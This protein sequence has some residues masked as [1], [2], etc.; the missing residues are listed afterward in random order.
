VSLQHCPSDCHAH[1]LQTWSGVAGGS[2]A[3]PDHEYPSHLEL[4]LTDT[5][6]R[7]TSA[8]VTRRLDPQTVPITVQS[9]PAGLQLTI[10]QLSGTAPVTSTLIVGSSTTV[11]APSPQTLA[12]TGYAFSN[13]SDGGGQTHNISAGGAARTYTATYVA[14]GGTKWRI[15]RATRLWLTRSPGPA[16]SLSSAV[17]RGTPTVVSAWCT[18]RIR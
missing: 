12:G 16:P 4:R 18:T 3:A 15:T 9:Q 8:T 10:G 2:I 11:S 17:I 14:T 1:P 5:D 13:W 6:S 7:G